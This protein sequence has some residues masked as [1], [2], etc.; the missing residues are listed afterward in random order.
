[1]SPAQ[2]ELVRS[3]VEAFTKQQLS[4]N[5]ISDEVLRVTGVKVPKATI[6]SMVKRIREFGNLARR[7]GS[8]RRGSLRGG[9]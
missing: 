1:M 5:K 7:P 3:V 8:G 6:Q 9:V 2:R 4:Y